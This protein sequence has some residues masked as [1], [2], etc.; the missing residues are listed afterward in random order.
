MSK[1]RTFSSTDSF[2]RSLFSIP[3]AHALLSS[4]SAVEWSLRADR[5]KI[6]EVLGDDAVL[7]R[8]ISGLGTVLVS[9]TLEAGNELMRRLCSL[10]YDEDSIY[11]RCQSLRIVDADPRDLRMEEVRSLNWIMQCYRCLCCLLIQIYRGHRR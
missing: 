6:E 5:V 8:V 1:R 10:G 2:L 9:G 7:G 11:S 4:K 3:L